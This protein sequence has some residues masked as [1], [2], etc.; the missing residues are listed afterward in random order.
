MTIRVLLDLKCLDACH[1]PRQLLEPLLVMKDLVN[2]G[3]NFL[4]L[5][6]K[7][8]NCTLFFFRGTFNN[9]VDKKGWVGSLKIALF[10]QVWYI[11][12]VYGGRWVVKIRSTWLLNV[13]LLWKS[14]TVIKLRASL[15]PHSGIGNIYLEAIRMRSNLLRSCLFSATDAASRFDLATSRPFWVRGAGT[16]GW[17]K[18]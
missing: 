14:S 6:T 4:R 11:K 2:E 16:G 8:L 13:P 7:N 18:I 12:N 3:G 17:F 1:R 10:V 9:H 15:C 5:C